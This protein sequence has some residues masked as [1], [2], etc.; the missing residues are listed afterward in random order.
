MAK[1]K[2]ALIGTG[3][4]ASAL[5]QGIKYYSEDDSKPGLWHRIIGGYKVSDVE[6]VEA[7]DID[8]NKVGKKLGEAIFTAPNTTERFVNVDEFDIEVKAGLLLD[9]GEPFTKDNT[10]TVNNK[11]EVADKIKESGAE[12][13]LNLISSGMEN[14][15]KAYCEAS[16]AANAS[17]LNATTAHLAVDANIAKK[18]EEAKLVIVGDDL[19]S[20]FGGTAFHRGIV[21]FINKR[22]VKILHSYQLDVGGGLETLRTIDENIKS[23]KREVKTVAIS[24]ELPYQIQSVAGTTDFV[25]F[26]KNRRTSYFWI[27]GESFLG[28]KVTIDVYLKTK[29]GPNAGNVLLDVIRAIYHAKCNG[30]YGAVNEICCYGFKRPPVPVRLLD[31]LEIFVR[32]Y[33]G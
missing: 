20:Q 13:V 24:S 14:S 7:F 12:I 32:K 8:K 17:F 4:S 29:D 33:V 27:V 25:E 1:I 28:S 30:E 15:S 22:G 19:M 3:N 18:F 16:L 6:V 23:R 21:D 9:N 31:G 26:M 10:V 5:V 2:V 11:E